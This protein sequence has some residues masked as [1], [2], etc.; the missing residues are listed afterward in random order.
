MV[1]R[2]LFTKSKVAPVGKPD[3]VPPIVVVL[4]GGSVVDGEFPPPHPAIA[5]AAAADRESI[6]F[7]ENIMFDLGVSRLTKIKRKNNWKTKRPSVN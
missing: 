6:N 1:F 5:M 2:P 3:A 7:F 4:T